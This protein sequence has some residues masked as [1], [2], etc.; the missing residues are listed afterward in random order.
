MGFAPFKPHAP[1]AYGLLNQITLYPHN[2]L[3]LVA[4]EGGL[5]ALALYAAALWLILKGCVAR[6]D[7]TASKG[8]QLTGWA[9][10]AAFTAMFVQGF[11]TVSLR[12]WGPMALYW[13]LVGL[14]LAWPRVEARGDDETA[15][16]GRSMAPR[17]TRGF[18][19]AVAVAVVAAYVVVW[20][21][22]HAMWLMGG[23]YRFATSE[24][25]G[26][27]VLRRAEWRFPFGWRLRKTGP[28]EYLRDMAL[29]AHLTRYLPHYLIAMHRQAEQYRREGD[30]ASAIDA[31]EAL[32][33][34]APGY[35]YTRRTLG[36]L[37]LDSA[38]RNAAQR[39]ELWRKSVAWLEKALEQNPYDA[40]ARLSLAE[41][42][43]LNSTL[44]MR[45]VVAHLGFVC[46]QLDRH[47]DARYRKHALQVLGKIRSLGGRTAAPLEAELSALEARLRAGDSSRKEK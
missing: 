2:E 29:S 8:G 15:A 38:R 16:T 32:E 39:A 24:T 11:V 5:F 46:D 6:A 19:L 20:Q 31:Y 27:R 33:R 12:F 30:Y 36:D 28:E 4:V 25:T 13:T 10:V 42:L 1:M 17:R 23:A 21:G 3:L 18:A 41:A 44:D 37:C 26:K 9:L 43:L 7:A 40:R 45:N 34:Q 35:G 14:L 22:V 47:D